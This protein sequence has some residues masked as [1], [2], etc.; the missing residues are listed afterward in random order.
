MNI[1]WEDNHKNVSDSLKL[2]KQNISSRLFCCTY[3]IW[4]KL[5]GNQIN[6]VFN[7]Q[8][9]SQMISKIRA[10]KIDGWLSVYS[11]CCPGDGWGDLFLNNWRKTASCDFMC[12][13][14]YVYIKWGK[15]RMCL[16]VSDIVLY[17]WF[18][19]V[20]F[21]SGSSSTV[22]ISPRFLENLH[23]CIMQ[24]TTARKQTLLCMHIFDCPSSGQ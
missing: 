7:P 17:C 1:G 2:L 22:E 19:L 6:L 9:H 21:Q 20:F 23:T 10:N 16:L 12:C 5:L 8:T 13:S 15:Q 4:K 11:G 18:V 14:L 3:S 24:P